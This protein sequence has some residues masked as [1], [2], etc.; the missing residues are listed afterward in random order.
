MTD[1]AAVLERVG[2]AEAAER[3]VGGFSLGMRQRLG[4][5]AALM[6][7]PRVLLLD[8]PANGLD[9][10]G[11]DDL[12]QTV[13]SLADGGHGRAALQ[14]RSRDD[15]RRLR[16]DQR[17]ARGR[18]GVERADRG[19]ARRGAGTRARA[20]HQRRRGGGRD[21]RR[22]RYP[23]RARARRVAC[24]RRDLHAGALHGGARSRR[25]RLARDRPGR[26]AAAG[27]V[28]PADRGAGRARRA[29]RSH[30]CRGSAARG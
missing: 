5:A 22:A 20:A 27:A 15:R 30:R 28:R 4:L 2:L 12:W 14:P 17:A 19:P 7:R 10:A 25:H 18:G 29:R 11:A 1:A 9:P 24:R 16:R 8:E 13:R 26:R 23:G 21:R 6:R 3:K